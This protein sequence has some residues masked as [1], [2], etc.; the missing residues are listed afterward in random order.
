MQYFPSN[1]FLFKKIMKILNIS[2]NNKIN[3]KT[4]KSMC[5]N[6]I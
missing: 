6:H 5:Q 2:E 4:A 1:F 3:V